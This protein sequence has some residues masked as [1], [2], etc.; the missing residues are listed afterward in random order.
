MVQRCYAKVLVNFYNYGHKISHGG[1]IIFS[2][3][4][5][6]S[7]DA[8]YTSRLINTIGPKKTGRFFSLMTLHLEKNFRIKKNTKVP[9]DIDTKVVK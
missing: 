3:L 6:I 1:A 4:S 9:L 2:S 5:S 7:I 8:I